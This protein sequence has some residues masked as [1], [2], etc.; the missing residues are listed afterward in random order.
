MNRLCPLRIF[1]IQSIHE[2]EVSL[3]ARLGFVL[4]GK[5]SADY[6]RRKE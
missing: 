6:K 3:C 2:A 4:T 5:K 1:L